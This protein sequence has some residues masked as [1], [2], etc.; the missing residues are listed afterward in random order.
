MNNY[1]ILDA[2]LVADPEVITPKS[3]DKFTKA[4]VADNPPGKKDPAHPSRFVTLKAWGKQG[5]NLAK[6]SKLDVITPTGELGVEVY[7]DKQGVEQRVDV[8]RLNG[9]R[10]QKSQTFFEPSAETDQSADPGAAVPTTKNP[11]GV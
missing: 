10:V 4:R 7:T 9:F 5:E 6:L 8:M 2:R 11:F 1:V 3:G